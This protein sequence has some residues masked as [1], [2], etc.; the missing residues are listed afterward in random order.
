MGGKP[1]RRIAD[2]LAS[3]N[4]SWRRQMQVML[5]VRPSFVV[6]IPLGGARQGV[7]LLTAAILASRVP[8]SLDHGRGTAGD[9]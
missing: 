7:L 6:P 1:A 2:R 9:L 5:G 4:A 8:G 3:L